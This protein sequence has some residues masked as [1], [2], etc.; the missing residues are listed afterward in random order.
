M[1]PE[2][3]AIVA[4]DEESRARL[5][6][7]EQRR[8]RDVAAA[9]AQHERSAGDLQRESCD[10]LETEIAAIREESDREIAKLRR[11]HDRYLAALAETGERQL[12][13]A[14]ELYAQIVGGVT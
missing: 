11:S 10:A 5:S 12:E 7:A 14:A 3:E 8:E 6:F 4:A 9:R 2:L 1:I 13:R